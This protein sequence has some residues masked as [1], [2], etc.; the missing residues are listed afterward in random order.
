MQR[1][2]TLIEIMAAV[3]IFAVVMTISMG[4]IISIFDAN[5]KSESMKSVMDNLNLSLESL[6]REMRFGTSY[7]CGLSG[8]LSQPQD[9]PAGD[10]AVAFQTKMGTV[11][12]KLN[13]TEIDKST[14]GGNTYLPVTAAEVNVS[15]LKFFVLGS[16]VGDGLQPR[17][18]VKIKGS[19]QI[20]N[21]DRTDFT[22]QTLV[23][24]RQKDS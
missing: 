15:D 9:C 2:F 17:A 11:V 3:A 16:S 13:G 20:K 19:S 12:Y 8:N 14:D 6:S 10:T 18:F 5:R 1:G 24:E 21:A 23:S 4:S 7:H 22:V